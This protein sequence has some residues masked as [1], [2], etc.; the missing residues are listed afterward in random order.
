M[1][2]QQTIQI[3]KRPDQRDCYTMFVFQVKLKSFKLQQVTVA[4]F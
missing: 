1:A 3:L 4:N 2:L